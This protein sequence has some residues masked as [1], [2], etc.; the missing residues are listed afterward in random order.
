M[1]GVRNGRGT[2]RPFIYG[3]L[4]LLDFVAH[5]FGAVELE[6]NTVAGGFH[7]QAQ[8]GDSVVVLSAMEPPY[9]AATRASTYV[10]VD[11]VDATYERAIAAG[12]SSLGKPTDRPFQERT[13]S[14]TDAFGNLWY[15]AT[16]IG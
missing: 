16:Y 11:D 1:G 5:V 4:D 3:R 7:V 8:I 10:Y 9:G 2:V 14:V 15:L 13:A 12:A 6:R